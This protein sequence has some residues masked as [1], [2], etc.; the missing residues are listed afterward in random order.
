MHYYLYINREYVFQ[1]SGVGVHD[2][3]ITEFND[4]KLK[5]APHNYRYFIYKIEKDEE[6]VI[7]HRGERDATYADFAAQ[8]A[9]C[10]NECRYGLI[11][12]DFI[13]KDGRET[14][15]LVFISW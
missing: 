7:E 15:K 8:L 10:E 6:I 5:K 1:S 12:L 11:D 4:F 14:S 2:D 13:T 3:V 9:S